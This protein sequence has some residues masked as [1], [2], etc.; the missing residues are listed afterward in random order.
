MEI[1]DNKELH[2]ELMTNKILVFNFITF[3][4][5]F[6]KDKIEKSFV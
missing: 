5:L 6:L 1:P 3:Y 4:Y 2:T